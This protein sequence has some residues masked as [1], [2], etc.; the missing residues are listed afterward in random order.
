MEMIL[1][2]LILGGLGVTSFCK[3]ADIIYKIDEVD[4]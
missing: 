1:G 3:L 4:E 2:I